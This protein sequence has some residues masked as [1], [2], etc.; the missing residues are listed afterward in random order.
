VR[1]LVW[2]KL[3]I[4]LVLC[5]MLSGCEVHSPEDQLLTQNTQVLL[6]DWHVAG[7]WVINSPVAWVRVYN[8]NMVPIKEIT[9]QYN[10]YTDDGKPL[11]QGTFTI[12]GQ[13]EPRTSK[14][15]IELYLGLVDLPSQRLNIKLL[16]VKRA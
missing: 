4:V 10:T 15:F 5:L 11:N 16:S 14:N 9:F 2:Q 1:H 13:V 6:M 7:L 8:Y 3:C 12:E